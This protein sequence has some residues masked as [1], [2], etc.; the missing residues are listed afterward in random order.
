MVEDVAGPTIGLESY[1]DNLIMF[2]VAKHYNHETFDPRVPLIW[3]LK[4]FFRGVQKRSKSE[5]S[6]SNETTMCFTVAQMAL[7]IFSTYF[8]AFLWP[9]EFAFDII[10]L[11]C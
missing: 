3:D 4:D 7:L 8:W 2:L 5:S 6:S 10:S 11:V 1:H 9:L